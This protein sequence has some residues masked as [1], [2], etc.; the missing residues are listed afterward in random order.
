MAASDIAIE[1]VTKRFGGTQALDD[2]S[3]ALSPGAV[4][5]VVGENGAGKS[6]LIKIL[7]G[8]VRPDQGPVLVAGRPQ[9]F[10]SPAGALAA[11]I[12]AGSQDVPGLPG[13]PVADALKLG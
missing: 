5:A 12:A 13:L 11:G 8:V 9:D 4:H 6:T 7:A 10:Q 2:V 1:A 3:L